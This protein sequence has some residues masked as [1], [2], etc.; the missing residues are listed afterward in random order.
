MK[1]FILSTDKDLMASMQRICEANKPS[2]AIIPSVPSMQAEGGLNALNSPDLILLD[3]NSYAGKAIGMLEN[4]A[5]RYPKAV[6]MLLSSDRSPETLIA[7]MRLGV[8][9]VV[10]L[11]AA[12]GDLEAALSRITEKFDRTEKDEGKIIAFISCKGGSGTTFIAANLAYALSTLGRKRVL[13]IDLNQ[14]FGDVALYVSDL[15]TSVA[16]SE[17][18][19]SVE[20]LDGNLLETSALHVTPNLSILAASDQIESSAEIRPDQFGIFLQIARQHYDFTVMDLGRQIN[21]VN[22]RALDASDRV[23]PVFQQ[24]L[25]YLRN[26]RRLFDIFSALGYLMQAGLSWSVS[27]F[28][29]IGTAIALA[30]FFCLELLP[31]SIGMVMALSIIAS[32]APWVYVIHIRSRRLLLLEEQLP[33]MADFISRSLRAG[34]AFSVSLQMLVEEMPQPI[35]SEFR[36]VSD[37]ISFGLPLSEALQRLCMR[38]PLPDLHYLVVAILIQR[39]TGGN[40]A[41]LMT[42]VS[43]LVR[44]RLKLQGDVRVLS[45]EGRM[46]AWILCLLSPIVAGI[47]CLTNPDYLQQFIDDPAG[48]T[49]LWSVGAML[50]LGILVMRF[51]VRIRV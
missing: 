1:A 35:A 33:E 40:L 41:E 42:K 7:A 20:R 10:P 26:G 6:L 18:C 15:K 9:E 47:F 5:Q 28:L 39:E 23:Y 17:V 45:A 29:A 2:V 32:L 37:E 13:L 12:Q 21:P 48:V 24:S 34:H 16:L 30:S 46:S 11:P 27:Q 50:V 51:I 43:Q 19:S 38:V 36:I 4:L 3:A 25:P 22:V 8:R 31:M 14:Q 44:Q 49:L